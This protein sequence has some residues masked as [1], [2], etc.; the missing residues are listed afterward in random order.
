MF[1]AA[2]AFITCVSCALPAFRPVWSEYE[3]MKDEV[4]V[5]GKIEFDPPLIAA[6]RDLRAAA[7][8]QVTWDGVW[9]IC[10]KKI[11]NIDGKKLSPD[12]PDFSEKIS[13]TQGNAF[14]YACDNAPFYLIA[15]SFYKN[16]HRLNAGR[17]IAGEFE[18]VVLPGG[19][20]VDVKSG[21]EAVYIGTIK[22]T[23]DRDFNTVKIEVKD[24]YDREMPVFRRIFGV[25]K[26]RKALVKPPK[27]QPAARGDADI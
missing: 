18:A 5:A 7:A 3:I 27:L 20:Y 1:F 26:L 9:M 6:G 21:D 24:D 15:G 14:Y 13:A 2:A 8:D 4:L 16:I 19:F 12:S 17:G 22:Y 25:M 10:G 23:L 11:R